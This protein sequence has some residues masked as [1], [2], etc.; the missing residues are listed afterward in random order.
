MLEQKRIG[1]R[2]KELV[3]ITRPPFLL[4]VKIYPEN[5]YV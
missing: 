4:N 1:K 3:F 2:Q 5:N